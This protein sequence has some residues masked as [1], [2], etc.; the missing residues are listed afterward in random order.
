MGMTEAVSSLWRLRSASTGWKHSRNV[1]ILV[2]IW[3]SRAL[4]GIHCF[5]HCQEP[6]VNTPPFKEIFPKKELLSLSPNFHIHVSVSDLYIPRISPHIFLQ[7][8]RIIRIRIRIRTFISD[9]VH[10]IIAIEYEY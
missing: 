7:Q 6:T 4:T 10:K 5:I 3:Q 1:K 2:D 9:Q 8:N